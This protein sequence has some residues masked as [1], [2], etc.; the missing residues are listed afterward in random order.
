[1]NCIIEKFNN[2]SQCYC[3]Y[4]YITEDQQMPNTVFSLS[5]VSAIGSHSIADYMI[6]EIHEHM[7]A[8]A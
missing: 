6:R 3:L 7:R 4:Y 5:T 1:M 8:I 2:I